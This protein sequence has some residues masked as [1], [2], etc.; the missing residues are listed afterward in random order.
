MEWKNKTSGEGAVGEDGAEH[1]RTTEHTR[2]HASELLLRHQRLLVDDLQAEHLVL[3]FRHIKRQ[4]RRQQANGQPQ[5]WAGKRPTAADA[6]PASS[7][8]QQAAAARQRGQQSAS[9]SSRRRRRSRG[10]EQPARSEIATRSSGRKATAIASSKQQRPSV[11]LGKSAIATYAFCFLFSV[12]CFLLPVFCFLAA[13]CWLLSAIRYLLSVLCFPFSA[14]APLSAF[15][16]PFKRGQINANRYALLCCCAVV[17]PVPAV[18]LCCS[19]VLLA[20]HWPLSSLNHDVY[21]FEAS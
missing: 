20:V 16:F 5:T 1:A 14:R 6:R 8:Q 11:G 4:R 19:A 10:Q 12:F 18:L 2:I 21:A 3:R 7:N 15:C 13:G 17:R 9:S